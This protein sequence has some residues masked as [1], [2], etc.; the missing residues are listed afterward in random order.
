PSKAAGPALGS[1]LASAAAGF[2][3]AV[4]VGLL[5]FSM[6][7]G[8]HGWI[9]SNVSW[10]GLALVPL[11]GLAWADRRRRRGQALALVT[12]ALAVAA[13]VAIL[14]AIRA[15]GTEYFERALSAAP[16]LVLPWFALWGAWQIAMAVVV[17]GGATS[18][19]TAA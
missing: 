14:V 8:G 12:L 15:E 6:A 2:G 16:V 13:D 3:Y 5:A 11:A 7:G 17:V 18:A 10:V 19:G 9:A 4:L 1:A